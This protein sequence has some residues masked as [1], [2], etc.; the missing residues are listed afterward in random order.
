MSIATA[1]QNAQT[2]VAN[3]YTAVSG[4]GWTLPAT[5]NLSNLPT[6]I[7]SIP[8]W[9]GSFVWIPREIVN[10]TMQHISEN[11]YTLPAE[12]T[13]LW[14]YALYGGFDGNTNITSVDMNNLVT[15]DGSN[16]MTNTFYGCSNL[17]TISFP[18]LVTI[19]GDSVMSSCFRSCTSLIELN[20]PKLKTINGTNSFNNMCNRCN[21]LTTVNFSSVETITGSGVMTNAFYNC[22]NLTTISFPKLKT[23]GTNSSST[24][25]GHLSSFLPSNSNVTTLTFPELEAIYTNGGTSGSYGSLS[26]NPYLQ[27]LYFPKLT[28]ITYGDWAS[29]ANRAAC[30]NTFY[31]CSAL[32][33]LHFAAANQSAI[34][35]TDGY[36]TAWGRWAGNVTIYFDL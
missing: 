3:A 6:A 35:A 23:I 10:G 24:N 29:T 31:G 33:E 7:N 32:T 34:Q 18:N 21:S 19:S 8:S 2:R 1:I 36:S 5:Q 9:W 4:K 16:A 28:T 20:F 12:V 14:D 26:N 17:T 13:N 27:K 11:T 22:S 30:K 25:N 15:I